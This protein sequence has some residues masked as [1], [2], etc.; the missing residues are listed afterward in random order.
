M[1][2]DIK[3]ETWGDSKKELG[4]GGLNSSVVLVTMIVLCEMKNDCFWK[5]LVTIVIVVK[6]WPNV[7]PWLKAD[8]PSKQNIKFVCGCTKWR[9]F[10]HT[11]WEQKLKCPQSVSLLAHLRCYSPFNLAERRPCVRRNTLRQRAACLYITVQEVLFYAAHQLNTVVF[12]TSAS[13]VTS[14]VLTGLFLCV[15]C[16]YHNTEHSNFAKL[17]FHIRETLLFAQTVH[18]CLSA[19]WGE[20]VSEIMIGT[21]NY[22][23]LYTVLSYWGVLTFCT[24]CV[25]ICLVCFVASFKLCCV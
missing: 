15:V 1:A 5:I 7:I 8:R 4:R 6:L 23:K 21:N 9:Q 22:N 12:I 16:L 2:K 3:A 17:V 19:D 10:V 14:R 20:S 18:L 13:A 11:S 25:V 24:C